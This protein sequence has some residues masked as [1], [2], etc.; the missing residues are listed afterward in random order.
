MTVT[1]VKLLCAC[2]AHET[3]DKAIIFLHFF[4]SMQP[5]LGGYSTYNT[6]KVYACSGEGGKGELI[7][8]IYDQYHAVH[9]TW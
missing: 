7:S 1:L 9:F 4:V 2:F 3:K 6:L 5:W 8:I